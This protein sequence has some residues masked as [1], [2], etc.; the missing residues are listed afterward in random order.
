MS[1]LLGTR[2]W[3]AGVLSPTQQLY[4]EFKIMFNGFHELKSRPMKKVINEQFVKIS[5]DTGSELRK[6]CKL[7]D[8]SS[9]QRRVVIWQ[10]KDCIR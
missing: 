2:K 6:R 8:E 10:E 5:E 4:E 3:E 1:I 9:I 7:V